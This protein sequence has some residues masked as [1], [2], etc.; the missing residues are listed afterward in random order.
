MNMQSISKIIHLHVLC[1]HMSP[2]MRNTCTYIIIIHRA[3]ECVLYCVVSCC[4]SY[5]CT[6]TQVNTTTKYTRIYRDRESTY[7][8]STIKSAVAQ[9]IKL[10]TAIYSHGVFKQTNEQSERMY[11][12][13]CMYQYVYVFAIV[14]DKKKTVNKNWEKATMP[15]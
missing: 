14:R 11:V 4:V 2:W 7:I 10:S 1:T 5:I 9:P 13:M 15:W 12:C 3:D 6:V 8:L